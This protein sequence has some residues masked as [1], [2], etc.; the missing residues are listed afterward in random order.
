MVDADATRPRMDELSADRDFVLAVAQ[1]GS[2]LRHTA[3]TLRADREVVLAAVSQHGG[4]LYHAAAELRADREVV[5]TA[6]AQNGHALQYAAAELQ[7]D[8]ALRTL[9]A[10]NPRVSAPLLAASLRLAFGSSCSARLRSS[11]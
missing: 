9:S 3:A 10:L 2:T 11:R 4:A 5:L 8:P 6:V 1:H 7:A